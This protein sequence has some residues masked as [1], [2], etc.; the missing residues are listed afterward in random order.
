MEY[1][2]SLIFVFFFIVCMINLCVTVLFINMISL[3]F[4]TF[5]F[6]IPMRLWTLATKSIWTLM[7]HLQMYGFHCIRK[8]NMAF[9]NILKEKYH[10]NTF[11]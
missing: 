2:I 9:I 10:K 3:L 7:P 8:Q 1:R 5:I 11:Q 4:D 6:I